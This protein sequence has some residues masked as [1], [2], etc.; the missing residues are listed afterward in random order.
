M[1]NIL[2]ALTVSL[3]SPVWAGCCSEIDLTGNYKQ[4]FTTPSKNILCGG[5]SYKRKEAKWYAH[6]LYCFVF[7]MKNAPKSCKTVGSSW[8]LDFAFNR[9][10]KPKMGCAGFEFY[11]EN[12]GEEQTRT[13]QYGETVKGVGWSCTALKTGMRCQNDDGHGFLLNKT[14]YQFF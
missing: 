11:P 1:K 5:D 8:G 10:G 7:D 13:L 2:L 14:S 4:I 9:T 12:T 3:A 6:D